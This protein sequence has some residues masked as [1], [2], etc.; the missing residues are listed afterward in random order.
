MHWSNFY[1]VSIENLPKLLLSNLYTFG[2]WSNKLWRSKTISPSM[3]K[4]KIIWIQFSVLNC[5]GGNFYDWRFEWKES[6][7]WGGA[8]QA[9]GSQ[10]TL[11]YGPLLLP[12]V[13]RE[14]WR[15]P[16]IFCC[17]LICLIPPPL[18]C[19]HPRTCCVGYTLD[20]TILTTWVR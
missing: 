8:M 5:M 13:R 19:S 17:R 9:T 3:N 14:Y 4:V 6:L 7:E 10:F 15:D 12:P 16:R 18:S 11:I 20:T 1:H 2:C